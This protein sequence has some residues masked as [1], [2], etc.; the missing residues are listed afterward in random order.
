MI[1]CQEVVSGLFCF[2][3]TYVYIWNNIMYQGTY[4][5]FYTYIYS[6][7]VYD[8]FALWFGAHRE[9]VFIF[10]NGENILH[11]SRV[12]RIVNALQV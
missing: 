8:V 10:F 11:C 1:V 7:D 5:V 3:Y 9:C 4:A 6:D 2:L 12:I